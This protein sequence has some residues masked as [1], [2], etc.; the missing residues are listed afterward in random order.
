[1]FCLVELSVSNDVLYECNF[2]MEVA[3]A[4]CMVMLMRYC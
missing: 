1:L 2:V 4:M 3:L